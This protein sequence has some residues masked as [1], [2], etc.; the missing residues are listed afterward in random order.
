MSDLRTNE[1]T[2]E[3]NDIV[4]YMRAYWRMMSD[5]GGNIRG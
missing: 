4:E 5:K 3:D 1:E 2:L